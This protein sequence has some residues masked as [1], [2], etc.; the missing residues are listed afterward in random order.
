MSRCHACYEVSNT[1]ISL[2]V[3][4][5]DSAEDQDEFMGGTADLQL[6]G[7]KTQI[8]IFLCYVRKL[9]DCNDFNRT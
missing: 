3:V 9:A 5:I 6:I 4:G 8:G 2:L 7:I 1:K